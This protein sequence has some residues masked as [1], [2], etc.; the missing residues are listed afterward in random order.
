MQVL[1]L[2]VL[3][4]LLCVAVWGAPPVF[5][6]ETAYDF[7]T[8]KQGTKLAHGFA[9]KNNTLAPVT[10]N[11]IE[12][13]MRGMTARFH[14]LVAP[15]LESTIAI[16]WDTSQFANV[17]Q[18]QAIVHFADSSMEPIT[19]RLK[20]VVQP[21]VEIVPF[22]AVFLSAFQGENVEARLRIVNHQEQP[23]AI[24]LNQPSSKHFEASLTEV[25]R[26]K[27]YELVTRIQTGVPPG[28]YDEEMFLAGDPSNTAPMRLPVHL[29]VKGDLY[30]NPDAVDFG[31]VPLDRMRSNNHVRDLLT[32]TF[33]V[34]KRKGEFAIT[35]I[36]SDLEVLDIRTDPQQ[37]TSSVYRI[38]VALNPQKADLGKLEG[39]IVIRTDDK[40][41]P[42]IR[43]PVTG[44]LF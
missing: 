6:P 27:V 9:I 15:G 42:E 37:A 7:G 2:H 24:S 31:L 39:V 3:L 26:G 41:F 11:G 1:R 43:V 20:A 34:K 16:E 32:Q 22:P 21:P 12:F 10:I 14:P 23:L 38:D 25:E 40:D 4:G 36:T 5:S 30:A 8:V 28:R 44:R 29:F 18:G 17:I 13:S 19:L 33:L 35:K